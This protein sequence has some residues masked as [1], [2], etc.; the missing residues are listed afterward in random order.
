MSRALQLILNFARGLLE[1]PHS[2]AE[3]FHQFRDFL[4]AEENEENDTDDDGL[5]GSYERKYRVLHGEVYWLRK[6]E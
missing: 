6:G 5:T 2:G 3:S 4:G 1:F